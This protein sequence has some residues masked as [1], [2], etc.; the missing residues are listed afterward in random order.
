[1]QRIQTFRITDCHKCI[2]STPTSACVAP[3][4]NN[5]LSARALPRSI[6]VSMAHASLSASCACPSSSSLRPSC[7]VGHRCRTVAWWSSFGW[8]ARSSRRRRGAPSCRGRIGRPRG[9]RREK[10]IPPPCAH[11][12]QRGEDVPHEQTS[13]QADRRASHTRAPT[14][15][16][17]HRTDDE[18]HTAQPPHTRG[19][20]IRRHRQALLGD[21]ICV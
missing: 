3:P 21:R 14:R 6:R 8:R 15:R 10:D 4:S 13:T 11:H 9:H 16:R 19:E 7:V 12:Q 1:M 17:P 5:A 20:C 2:D 18:A